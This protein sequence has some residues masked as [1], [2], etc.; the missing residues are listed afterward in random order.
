MITMLIRAI[1][2]AFMGTGASLGYADV[3]GLPRD[4]KPAT[5][6]RMVAQG[7]SP[8]CGS[9]LDRVVTRLP[10]LF[11]NALC[12]EMQRWWSFFFN[13]GQS[14]TYMIPAAQLRFTWR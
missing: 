13:T 6:R 9:L 3:A 11:L 7:M 8:M 14:L 1:C 4:T 5:I 10:D 12:L 2:V